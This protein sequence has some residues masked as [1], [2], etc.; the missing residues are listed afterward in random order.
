MPLDI[1]NGDPI[2]YGLTATVGTYTITGFAQ[3]D[4]VTLKAIGEAT[5]TV[6]GGVTV[7]ESYTNPGLE[8]SGD[9]VISGTY[10]RLHI[11]QI[12][13]IQHPEEELAK[14]YVIQSADEKRD[15][16]TGSWIVSISAQHRYSMA[17][18]YDTGAIDPDTGEAYAATFRISGYVVLGTTGAAVSGVAVSD[19]TRSATTNAAGYYEIAN[20]PAGTY[21]LTPTKSGNTFTPAT[22]A[23]Q[24]VS[25]ANLSGKNFIAA[26]S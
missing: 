14:K 6:V 19:G 24:V 18:A 13:E 3:K 4:D 23:S 8:L 5:E 25:T 22:L 20:V 2:I 15:S 26:A 11:G 17:D 21:T 12:V 9:F 1:T 7:K 16:E 10:Q